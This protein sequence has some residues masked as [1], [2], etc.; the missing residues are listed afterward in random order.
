[1]KKI[2]IAGAGHG[3]LTAAFNLAKNGY[4]VTVVE[5]KEKES[6]G[7]DWH[8]AMNMSAFDMTGI[9]RPEAD[10]CLESKPQSFR[11]PSKKVRIDLPFNNTDEGFYI[12][13]KVLIA[14][15]ISCCEKAGVKFL[16]G[17]RVIAPLSRNNKVTGLKIACDNKEYCL[18]CDMVIDAAGMNSPVRRNLP[19]SCSVKK[20][21]DKK[22]VFHV[23]RAYFKNTTGETT[24]PPATINMFHLGRPGIDWT[25]T[26]KDFVDILVGKFGSAGELSQQEVDEAIDCF[27]KEYPYIGESIRGGQF[28]DIPLTK[29]LDMLVCDGYAAVGDSAGMT[30]PLNGCGIVLSM[31]AGRLLAD[32]LLDSDGDCSKQALWPYEYEYFQKLGKDLILI[33]TLKT[34]FAFIN[35]H[36]I[37][38]M[39]EKEILTADKLDF[40]SGLSVDKKFIASLLSAIPELYELIIP[41]IKNFSSYPLLPLVSKTMPKKYDEKKVKAWLKLYSKI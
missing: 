38:V 26:E 25:I 21:L 2:L 19:I 28:A 12:D 7:H 13:R 14:Y 35:A 32:T 30:V 41:L 36:H 5:A 33:N 31:K 17:H 24:D 23:Y 29:M 22:D 39:V 18:S 8:D 6:L 11:D 34:F 15:L 9:P 16:F 20:T 1:M 27:K 37:D 10:M 40:A 3:G 4:D